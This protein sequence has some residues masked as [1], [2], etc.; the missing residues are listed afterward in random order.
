[1]KMSTKKFILKPL[2]HKYRT[3]LGEVHKIISSFL[4]FHPIFPEYSFLS[5]NMHF[6]FFRIP[7]FVIILTIL[8]GVCAKCKKH[9]EKLVAP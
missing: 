3:I 1:M 6:C 2:F 9:L 5:F 8:L 4:C 7:L